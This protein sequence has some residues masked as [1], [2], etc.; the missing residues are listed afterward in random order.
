ME[1]TLQQLDAKYSAVLATASSN[2]SSAQNAFDMAVAAKQLERD[3][4]VAYYDA[5]AKKAEADFI[6]SQGAPVI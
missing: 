3:K 2:L 1:T 6:I 5:L 4:I